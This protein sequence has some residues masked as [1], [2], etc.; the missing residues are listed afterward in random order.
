MFPSFALLSTFPHLLSFKWAWTD[1]ALLYWFC[2]LNTLS[3]IHNNNC[4]Q[5]LRKKYPSPHSLQPPPGLVVM[6]AYMFLQEGLVVS[7]PL[8]LSDCLLQPLLSWEEAV[9]L[10]FPSADALLLPQSVCRWANII[11]RWFFTEGGRS[12]WWWWAYIFTSSQPS[13]L[14]QWQK[15]LRASETRGED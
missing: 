13:S 10:F 2:E 15:R 4:T 12:V 14:I 6:D 9:I 3:G 11:R 7:I 5:V 1:T 8:S